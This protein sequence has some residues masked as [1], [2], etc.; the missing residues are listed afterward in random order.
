LEPNGSFLF[1]HADVSVGNTRVVY[2][3]HELTRLEKVQRILKSN[4]RYYSNL[5]VCNSNA[6]FFATPR[7]PQALNCCLCEKCLRTIAELALENID[8]ARSNF[9]LR[10]PED[11]FKLIKTRLSYG[12]LTSDR[13]LLRGEWKDMQNN[14]VDILDNG[15]ETGNG[16]RGA[17]EFFEW[18]RTFDL[19]RPVSALGCRHSAI[20]D[21]H[22]SARYKSSKYAIG[23]LLWTMMRS[24]TR[25][26]TRADTRSQ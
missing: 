23:F 6:R 18:F 22:F 9:L 1:H 21:C 15:K 26:S 14:V 5:I 3:G 16:I 19:E 25:S 7:A 4:S 17:R 13:S 20:L 10:R 24:I 11:A 8:P 12:V 2:D